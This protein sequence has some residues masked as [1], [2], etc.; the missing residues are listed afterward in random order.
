[1]TDFFI[2]F[3][4]DTATNWAG[5][6]RIL[7]AGE[8]GY[9]ITNNQ[10]RVGDG[11]SGWGA[12]SPIGGGGGG[13][14]TVTSVALS[15]GTTGLTVTGSPITTSGTITLG[16]TLALANGGTGA[17]TAAAART[18]L[19]ATTVG[20]AVFTAVDAA[21]ARTAIG[22]G[23]GSGTVTSVSGTGTVSGLTLS[24]TVT[25]SGSLTL[26]GTL[27]VATAAIQDGAVTLGKMA[28]LAANS[29]IGNNTGSPATPLALTAAQVRTLIN[30]ADGATANSTDAAL[31]DRSTH[32]GTQSA[33]TITGLATVAT[34]GS[35]ADLTG[36]L[37]V[38]RLNGGTGASATT[39]WRG[40]GTWAT[41]AGGGSSDP[42]DLTVTNPAAPA[43]NT[44]RLFRRAI[45]N[46][47]MPAFVGPSGLDTALQPFLARNKIG[48]WTAPGSNTNTTWF[49]LNNPVTV[50][51]ATGRAVAAT[52]LFTRMRRLGYVSAATAGSLAVFRF[53]QNQFSIG[54]GSG[55]GGF[56]IV[57]RFGLSALTAD[58][59]AFFGVRQTGAPTNVEPS[60]LTNT[61]GIGRGAAD[62]TL[63]LFYGGT[64][65][66]TP[67]NLGANFP[68][69]TTNVDLYELALFSPP[70]VAETVHYQ[71][72]RLNT[73]D[74]A[75]GTLT[76][77][78]AVLPSATTLLTAFTAWISNNATAA[79]VAFDLVGVYIETDF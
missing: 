50:G 22:A 4:R 59:R 10:I 61:I 40:D 27:S 36:N 2:Q 58:A 56:H 31:R 70:G 67:I 17:T 78:A 76:G 12:L 16:G 34:S 24:G 57:A 21:A 79:A 54:D 45:A 74:T 6:S 39:F 19:G 42:L 7:A 48:L 8:P 3:R 38:A 73:G 35:A 32:T 25:T 15:G 52:N 23:T 64:T 51:T 75:T 37:A 66:Q 46:R 62:T 13:S 1:M 55:L 33:A 53:D 60:T 47:Q 20:S 43:A 71:V 5:S 69:N 14:G 68:A 44:V 63:Q 41:P 18:N 28:N 11:T 49:G 30:V 29:I 77:G 26:G 9:D 65:A 72:T